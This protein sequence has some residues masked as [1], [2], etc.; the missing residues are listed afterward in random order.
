MITFNEDLHAYF[1]GDKLVPS[2]T[3]VINKVYGSGLEN[4]PKGPVA[5][6]ADKGTSI[7][8]AIDCYLKT[9][10]ES[11]L[12]EFKTWKTYYSY[13]EGNSFESEKIVYAETPYG[14]VAGT[15][16]FLCQGE[17]TDWK[18]SKTAT[19]TQKT[20]WQMQ[21]SIYK[22]LME[23]MGYK[24]D[25]MRVVRIVGTGLSIL[26]FEY[27][28]DEWVEETM[29]VYASTKNGEKTKIEQIL[30]K[31]TALEKVSASELNVLEN[32]LLKIVELEKQA[33]AIKEKIKDEMGKRGI[34]SLNVG[35]VKMSYVAE[36]SSQRLDSKALK[37]QMPDVYFKFT[38]ETKV[39][40]S[41]RVTIED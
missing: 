26:N 12:Q 34:Y 14:M 18:T 9:G 25:V 36:H 37:E 21:L 20:H 35:K 16:D 24:I 17:L 15:V 7:H 27:L 31:E 23:K 10:E 39:K 40:P 19:K 6:A 5:R 13:Y 11:D 32:T 29:R 38:K 22:Y 33:E 3:Q 8:K 2:V 4:A 41:L 1:Y 30:P 28:G